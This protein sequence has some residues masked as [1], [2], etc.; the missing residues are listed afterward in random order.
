[1]MIER[2]RFAF[3]PFKSRKHQLILA[4]RSPEKNRHVSKA[5]RWQLGHQIGHLR[6]ERAIND[7]AHSTFV[8]IMR[9]N[10]QHRASEIRVKDVGMSDQQPTRE[11]TSL[12]FVI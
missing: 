10:K 4:N 11:A 3:F 8:W 1:M 12:S 2:E 6:I 5:G 9:G 7:H